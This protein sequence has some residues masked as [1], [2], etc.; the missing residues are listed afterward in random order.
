MHIRVKVVEIK[1]QHF[2][3]K[4]KSKQLMIRGNMVFLK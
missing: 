4:L 1:Q 2:W 3:S